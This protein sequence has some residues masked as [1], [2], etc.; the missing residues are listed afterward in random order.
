MQVLEDTDAATMCRRHGT[1]HCVLV[2]PGFQ[3]FKVLGIACSCYLYLRGVTRIK[4]SIAYQWT[5]DLG[6]LCQP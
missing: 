3:T 6:D 2:R 4:A 1:T 5:G